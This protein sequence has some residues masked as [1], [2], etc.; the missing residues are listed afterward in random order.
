MT[1]ERE[2]ALKVRLGEAWWPYI[3]PE[4][5]K[6]YLINIAGTIAA[7]R[8]KAIIYPL[9]DDIFAA[10]KACPPQACKVIILGQDPY[11]DGNATGKA[12]E[13]GLR[14]TGQAKDVTPSFD[15]ILHAYDQQFPLSFAT[16]LYEG[17]LD[18][19]AKEGVLLLNSAFTVEKGKAGSHEEL[20]EPFTQFIIQMLA[21]SQRPKFFIFL[22]RKA[23]KFQRFVKQPHTGIYRE[24]PAAACYDKRDWEHGDCFKVA[25]DFLKQTGQQ[26]VDW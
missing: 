6:E 24:H 8:D 25:N 15:K 14:K 5:D 2:A 17:D 20:W 3:G 19:W 16:D 18:R 23:Q 1:P 10:F 26:P 21:K 11:H 22:G 7:K 9:P 4:F 13:C 12:F